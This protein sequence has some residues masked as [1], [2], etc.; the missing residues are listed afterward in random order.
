MEPVTIK[1]LFALFGLVTGMLSWFLKMA[2]SRIE[3]MEKDIIDQREEMI[4]VKSTNL[5]QIKEQIDER[6]D[7]VEKLIENKIH[8]GFT[9]LELMWI[10][11]G[12]LPAKTRKP[13]GET[14]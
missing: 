7:S 11:E 10:N 8:E 14:Q 13:K 9:R 2:W 3:K 5:L 12:R 1:G 6:L 4:A